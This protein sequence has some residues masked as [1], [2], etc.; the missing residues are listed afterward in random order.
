MTKQNEALQKE[1]KLLS[2]DNIDR[3]TEEKLN[4]LTLR[5]QNKITELQNNL[6]EIQDAKERLIENQFYCM[7]CLQNKKNIVIQ[8][9]Q[10]FDL[11]NVCCDKL[12][13]KVCPRCQAP[14]SN[15]MHL[16]I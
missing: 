8:G 10:H 16:K 11:C 7:I 1:K 6:K 12:D 4:E 13:K 9:C 2:V 5:T 15:V 14:F 3:W